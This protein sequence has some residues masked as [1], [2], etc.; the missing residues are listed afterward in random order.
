MSSLNAT[1]EALATRIAL[2][3][4]DKGTIEESTLLKV[5]IAKLMNKVNYLKSTNMS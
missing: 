2:C 4:W 3:E 1:I 5:K